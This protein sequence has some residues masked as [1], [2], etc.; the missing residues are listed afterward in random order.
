MV[1]KISLSRYGLDNPIMAKYNSGDAEYPSAAQSKKLEASEQERPMKS[2]SV[3]LK[4][5]P[6]LLH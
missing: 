4:A 5:H 6:P 1:Y 3:R 2:G